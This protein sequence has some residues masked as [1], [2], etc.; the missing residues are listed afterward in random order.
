MRIKT[1]NEYINEQNN[2]LNENFW[3]WFGNSKLISNNKPNIYYHSSDSKFKIFDKNKSIYGHH[4]KGFYFMD[5]DITKEYYGKYL[6]KCYLKAVSPFDLNLD[7]DIEFIKKIF[8]DNYKYIED[9]IIEESELS[10][11]GKIP[12]YLFYAKL[13]SNG[14]D[15]LS[16]NGFD[17][18][19]HSDIIV[20]FN[21]NQI[22]SIVNDGSFDLDDDNIYS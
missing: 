16:S 12:G 17:S 4:G 18:I 15:I 5:S 9:F 21:S 19:K 1:F 7:Y 13:G 20:V 14:N 10:Y 6:Y 2:N 11:N 22:K 3:K 8:G